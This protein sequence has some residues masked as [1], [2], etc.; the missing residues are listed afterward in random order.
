[1]ASPIKLK[2]HKVL[3]KAPCE[4]VFQEMS[5][6]GRGRLK[7]GNNESSR[8]FCQDDKHLIA[9]FKTKAGPFSYTTITKPTGVSETWTSQTVGSF[10]HHSSSAGRSVTEQRIGRFT[11]FSGDLNGTRQDVGTGFSFL[12][13]NDR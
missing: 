2:T 8:V 12:N 3:I 4:M 13:W 5:Y 7:G 9:E 11:H 10:R 1:M 6:F